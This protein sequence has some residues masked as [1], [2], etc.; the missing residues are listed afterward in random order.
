VN[1][2]KRQLFPP[3]EIVV[4]V[5]YNNSL[6]Q[7]IKLDFKN[8]LVLKNK[9]ERG[10][11]GSRNT[12]LL[13]SS[14]T[15]LA[16]IDDDCIAS[17]RWLLNINKI[18]NDK[19]AIGVGGIIK[20]IWTTKKPYW[21]PEEFG[22][23]VGIT[24]KGTLK[25]TS[26]VR[27]IWSGNMAVRK[28]AAISVNGFNPV[29]SKINNNPLPE[30]TDFCV[31]IS[32]K[33]PNYYWLFNPIA[34]VYHKV[35]PYRNK[36]GYFIRRCFQEG[37]GKAIMFNKEITKS[38]RVEIDYTTQVLFGG[39]LNNLKDVVTKCDICGLMRSLAIVLGFLITGLG[40][41]N[42]RLFKN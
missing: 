8:C 15:L 24:N 19:N 40:F 5:D 1:S 41:L 39:L 23:V 13:A 36:L 14:G 21:F 18:F 11:G 6:F 33:W 3:K 38:M 22:W 16:F 7:K 2:L 29:F 12:G 37:G 34:V 27:N 17:P 25:G 35:Y 31:R 32:H 20:P 10:A 9:F 28:E 4:V 42:K 30:D 26:Q